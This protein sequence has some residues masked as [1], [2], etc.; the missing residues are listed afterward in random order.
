M[1]YNSLPN[2]NYLFKKKY[3]ILGVSEVTGLGN[4]EFKYIYIW[5]SEID[6]LTRFSF[7]FIKTTDTKAI[8]L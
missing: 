2:K 8:S 5:E 4:K 3:V 7:V 6:S 1:T